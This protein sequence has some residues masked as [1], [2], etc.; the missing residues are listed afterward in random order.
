MYIK[1]DFPDIHRVYIRVYGVLD[2]QSIP[3]FKQVF[4][5]H[6]KFEKLITL[7]LEEVRHMSRDVMD[8]LQPI[9]NES[10]TITLPK[11]IR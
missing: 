7:D 8:Y 10:I 11:F 5:R 4:E 9:R 3:L 6:L 2:S 1:E